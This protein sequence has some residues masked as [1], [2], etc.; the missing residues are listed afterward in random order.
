MPELSTPTTTTERPRIRRRRLALGSSVGA[1]IAAAA[2][3]LS[4]T[5]SASANSGGTPPAPRTDAHI[6][7]VT[8]VEDQIMAYYGDTVAANGDHVPSATGNYAKQVEHIEAQAKHYLATAHARHGLKRAVV[9]DVDDTTLNTYNYEIASQFGYDPVTNGA[10]VT[11]ERFP[12]VPGMPALFNW[13]ENHGYTVFL[14]TGRPESQ[15]K[16]TEG[17]LTKDGYQVPPDA[18]VFLKNS[19]SPPAY[20]TCGS[21]CTTDEYKSQT[22]A[23]IQSLGYDIVANFGDQFSDL[24]LGHEDRAFKIPNPMYF[25]P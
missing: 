8:L 15:R 25:L 5:S 22:R 17:N 3:I 11:A 23:H 24:S 2:L 7:N 14:I 13:A 10:Y 19:M 6:P 16:P 18:N 21:S 20:L 12:A 4:G 9:F 1:L